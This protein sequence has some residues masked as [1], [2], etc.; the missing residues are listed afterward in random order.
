MF[1]RAG[2]FENSSNSAM[3]TL[4]VTRPNYQVIDQIRGSVHQIMRAAASCPEF[5]SAIAAN[6]AAA[7]LLKV[8]SLVVGRQADEPHPNGRPKLPRQ[9]IIRRS[10]TLLE[11]RNGEPILVT[12]LAAAA[13]VSERT[14][15][16][17]FQ[18]YY[19][20]GPVRYLQLMR[21]H[22][23]YRVLSAA[24]GES[25]SV[26][27]VIAKH[28]EWDFGRFTARYRRLFGE[29]PSETLRSKKSYR[30]AQAS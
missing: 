11:E 3:R 6:F 10:Q 29:L 4:R 20:I 15:R 27:E 16:T 22:Q 9:E 8:A 18:D 26:S 5:E 21:L 12:E 30:S 17:A 14:L 28:G 2:A 19:G 24:D 7:E 23:V 1:A 13:R 25:V